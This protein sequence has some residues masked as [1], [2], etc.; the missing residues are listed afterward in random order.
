MLAKVLGNKDAFNHEPDILLIVLDAVPKVIGDG[1]RNED[2]GF[3]RDRAGVTL[4]VV[5]GEGVLIVLEGCLVELPILLV[6]DVLGLTMVQ[7]DTIRVVSLDVTH[8]VQRG[9]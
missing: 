2:D 1:A 6:G 3:E 9:A 7:S 8:R 5:P 4:E